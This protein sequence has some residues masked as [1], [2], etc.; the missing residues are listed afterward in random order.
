MCYKLFERVLFPI[1]LFFF[2]FWGFTISDALWDFDMKIQNSWT[3]LNHRQLLQTNVFWEVV[4]R[5]CYVK[6]VL[7]EISQNSQENTRVSFLINLQ[8]GLQLY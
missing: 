4:V 8:P 2:F 7:L 6:K 3:C 1:L 5:R